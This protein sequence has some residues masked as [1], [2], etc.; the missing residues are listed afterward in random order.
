MQ[1]PEIRFQEK[2]S[3]NQHKEIASKTQISTMVHH[4]D[5]DRERGRFSVNKYPTAFLTP[6]GLVLM[7]IQCSV[8]T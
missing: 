8:N 6:I 4:R 1:L 7:V 5:F 3:F 2:Y